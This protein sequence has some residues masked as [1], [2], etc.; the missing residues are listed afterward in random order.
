MR[1]SIGR[2]FMAGA[3]SVALGLSVFGIG[4]TAFQRAQRALYSQPT[5]SSIKTPKIRS[6]LLSGNYGSFSVTDE[7][8]I[9]TLSP[10][11]SRPKNPNPE[12]TPD[13]LSYHWA[14]FLMKKASIGA[15]DSESSS[16]ST[17]A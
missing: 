15:E 13:T 17:E 6:G 12:E 16:E 3:F 14:L 10:E 11:N 7:N 5:Q 1:I 4:S 9:T 2:F 8:R